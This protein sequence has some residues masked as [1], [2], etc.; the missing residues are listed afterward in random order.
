MADGTDV[1]LLFYS[2]DPFSVSDLVDVRNVL[3][4]PDTATVPVTPTVKTVPPVE[5]VAPLPPDPAMI[6]VEETKN[7]ALD[8]IDM[9]IQSCSIALFNVTNSRLSRFLRWQM[10]ALKK[11]KSLYEEFMPMPSM[12]GQDALIAD[13]QLL[14]SSVSGV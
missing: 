14:T 1:L 12:M 3:A 8:R 10:V 11:L 5:S 7:A 9:A 6:A 13:Q 2:E 4:T